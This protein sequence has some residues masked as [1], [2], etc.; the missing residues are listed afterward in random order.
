MGQDVSESL[1]HLSETEPALMSNPLN[2]VE[3]QRT[4]KL[5]VELGGSE[6]RSQFDTHA[7]LGISCL[8]IRHSP[9]VRSC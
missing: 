4:E 2:A 6:N 8:S 7:I 5:M 3:Q 9:A 1:G